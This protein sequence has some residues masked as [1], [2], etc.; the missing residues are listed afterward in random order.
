MARVGLALFRISAER[1]LRRSKVVEASTAF[2]QKKYDPVFFT[3]EGKCRKDLAKRQIASQNG[4]AQKS[5]TL[6]RLTCT[7]PKFESLS[8][9][10]HLKMEKF[11]IVASKSV[12]KNLR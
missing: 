1:L 10:V 11:R 3:C 8:N 5:R 9:L 12:T 6:S 2:L 4:V 7:L